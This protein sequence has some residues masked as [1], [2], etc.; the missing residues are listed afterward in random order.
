MVRYFNKKEE[1]HHHDH[2]DLD[3]YGTGDT[4]SLFDDVDVGDYYKPIF[5]KT[6]FK[7]DKEDESGYRIGYKLH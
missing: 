7:E 6:A 3:Y 5:V 1:Y 2:E 4:E